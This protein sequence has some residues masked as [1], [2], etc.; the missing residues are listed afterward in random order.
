MWTGMR[1]GKWGL[2]FESQILKNLVQNKP[3]IMIGI[4]ELLY[5][6]NNAN[7]VPFPG[8]SIF[9]ENAG[10]KGVGVGNASHSYENKHWGVDEKLTWKVN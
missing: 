6:S 10:V 2:G 1:Q 9:V 4:H 3:I 5:F 7:S 8:I